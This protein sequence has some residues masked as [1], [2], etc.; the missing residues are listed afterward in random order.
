MY[1]FSRIEAV[2]D[3]QI[4]LRLVTYVAAFLKRPSAVKRELVNQCFIT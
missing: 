1:G 4:N 3:L 2:I